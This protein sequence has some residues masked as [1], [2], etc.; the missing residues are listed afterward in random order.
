MP[1]SEVG[2]SCVEHLRIVPRLLPGK[3]DHVTPQEADGLLFIPAYS[4]QVIPLDKSSVRPIT[5]CI[6][7]DLEMVC[8]L[9][10]RHI[11]GVLHVMVPSVLYHRGG[12]VGL[13]CT[14]LTRMPGWSPQAFSTSSWQIWLSSSQNPRSVMQSSSVLGKLVQSGLVIFQNHPVALFFLV[15]DFRHG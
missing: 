11:D 7:S 1:F 3:E 12:W 15:S 5:D 4:R 8:H 9:L 14:I 10:W 6:L 2:C 13:S